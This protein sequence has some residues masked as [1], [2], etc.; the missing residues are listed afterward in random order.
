[1]DRVGYTDQM[2][3]HGAHVKNSSTH[4]L[5]P[6]YSSQFHWTSAGV[7]G[8]TGLSQP[9][10]CTIIILTLD[11]VFL[12]FISYYISPRRGGGYVL[13]YTVFLTALSLI[14]SLFLS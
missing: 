13:F 10:F 11:L 2:V 1:M 5:G 14:V 9:L 8:N 6:A 4:R 3:F 7:K 12:M